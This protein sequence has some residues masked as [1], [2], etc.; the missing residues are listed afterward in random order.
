MSVR[1]SLVKTSRVTAAPPKVLTRLKKWCSEEL[2]LR[3]SHLVP[4]LSDSS[5]LVRSSM[6]R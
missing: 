3:S 4:N 2:K 6:P 1:P 5:G